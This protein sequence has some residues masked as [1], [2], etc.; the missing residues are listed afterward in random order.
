MA[1][2][3]LRSKHQLLMSMKVK[4]MIIVGLFMLTFVT[5]LNKSFAGTVVARLPFTPPGLF[6]NFTHYGI[7]G[8]DFTECSI[9]F[10]NHIHLNAAFRSVDCKM[11]RD[12]ITH[13]MFPFY[14]TVERLVIDLLNDH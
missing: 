7:P 5:T 9:T 8:N 3:D 10:E 14:V 2:Q 6:R 12:N 11:K 1:E 13:E 4:G